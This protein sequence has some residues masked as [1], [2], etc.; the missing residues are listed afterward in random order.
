MN[1]RGYNPDHRIFVLEPD[2]RIG[3]DA[4]RAAHIVNISL[5]VVFV[6]RCPRAYYL[7]NGVAVVVVNITAHEHERCTNPSSHVNK[8]LKIGVS[9][10]LYLAQP[11][12]AY[13]NV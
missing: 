9:G 4:G 13:P 10:I 2:S 6:S 7:G 12:V 11:S 3:R 5:G 1:H 8:L